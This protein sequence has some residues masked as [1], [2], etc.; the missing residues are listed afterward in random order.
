MTGNDLLEY[1]C[2]FNARFLNS[3]KTL[4]HSVIDAVSFFLCLSNRV[5]VVI[6]I[7]NSN[8]KYEAISIVKLKEL[9]CNQLTTIL[10]KIKF[11]IT[12][13]PVKIMAYAA[14]RNITAC[15]FIYC[16]NYCFIINFFGDFQ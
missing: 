13:N 11:I 14:T 7:K 3:K 1:P 8:A 5:T 4:D 6:I 10:S 15:S 12:T 2:L 16:C 9:D